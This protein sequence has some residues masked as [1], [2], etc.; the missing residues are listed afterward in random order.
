MV[1][2]YLFTLSVVCSSFSVRPA[3]MSETLSVSVSSGAI[4]GGKKLESSQLNLH[5]QISCVSRGSMFLL[6]SALV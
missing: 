2:Q 6:A 3:G 4:V 5:P 1:F